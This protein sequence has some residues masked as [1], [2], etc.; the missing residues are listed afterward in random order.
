MYASISKVCESQFPKNQNFSGKHLIRSLLAWGRLN[1]MEMLMLMVMMKYN[2]AY[3][4]GDS[5]N[6]SVIA[7]DDD[8][9]DYDHD[10]DDVD[11]D[12]EYNDEE[13]RILI[14]FKFTDGL[15][16]FGFWFLNV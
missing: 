3:G 1:M 7:D 8:N 12:D 9:H 15:S 16:V 4:C 10:Y 6:Y 2:G 13:C 11:D 14:D 5:V